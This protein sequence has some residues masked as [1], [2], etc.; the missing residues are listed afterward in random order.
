[1]SNYGFDEKKNKV[2]MIPAA[3]FSDEVDSVVD[4]KLLLKQDQHAHKTGTL[5]TSGWTAVTGGYTQTINVAGVTSS[6]TVIVSAAPASADVYGACGV[7]CTAQ[8]SGT[9]TFTSK[10]TPASNL[11]VNV[12][13]LGV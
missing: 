5:T 8:G 4:P 13:I 7:I 12:V 10:S 1:M 9:L 3:D 2:V 11:T 6:N